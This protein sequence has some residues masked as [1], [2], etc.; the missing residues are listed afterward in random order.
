MMESALCFLTTDVSR[1]FRCSSLAA[2]IVFCLFI[3]DSDKEEWR[4]PHLSP[5]LPMCCK[6][7]FKGGC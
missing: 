6:G 5:W 4:V 2:F 1:S 7:N 3:S